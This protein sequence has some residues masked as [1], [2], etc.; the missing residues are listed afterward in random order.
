VAMTG[1]GD[2]ALSWPG[3]TGAHTDGPRRLPDNG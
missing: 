3:T 1:A 2:P